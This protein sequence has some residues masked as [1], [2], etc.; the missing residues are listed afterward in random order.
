MGLTGFT[1]KE[2]FFSVS[3]CLCGQTKPQRHRG[4]EISK[5]TRRWSVA[6]RAALL[7]KILLALNVV[8]LAQT[9]NVTPPTTKTAVD[10]KPLTSDEREELLKLIR[11]LQERVEKLEAAQSQNAGA[12]PSLEPAA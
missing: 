8:C 4:T 6:L 7:I 5:A 12:Q 10:N 9:Q 2:S 11:S 3:P 1:R